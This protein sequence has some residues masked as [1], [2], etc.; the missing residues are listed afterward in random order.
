M[1]ATAHIAAPAYAPGPPQDRAVIYAARLLTFVHRLI[2][3]GIQLA[4]AARHNPTADAFGRL[5]VRFGTKSPERII[6]RI[7]LALRRAAKLEQRLAGGR[8]AHLNPAQASAESLC[9]RKPRAPRCASPRDPNLP[10]LPSAAKIARLLRRKPFEMVL[11]QICRELGLTRSNELQAELDDILAEH[12]AGDIP[13][14][15]APAKPAPE[16]NTENKTDRGTA[17]APL[18]PDPHPASDTV[19]IATTA[20]GP[21]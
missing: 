9:P 20:T 18:P 3:F 15:Q 21:P 8:L 11:M 5:G 6:T 13:K 10:K 12:L 16:S 2:G 14:P 19:S 1:S 7:A 17:T 4:A